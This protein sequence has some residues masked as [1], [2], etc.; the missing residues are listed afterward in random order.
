MGRRLSIL[1]ARYKGLRV[2]AHSYDRTTVLT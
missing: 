1:M 2:S